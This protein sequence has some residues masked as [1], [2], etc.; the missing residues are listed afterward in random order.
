L[1]SIARRAARTAAVGLT[2][3]SVALFGAVAL[4][5]PASATPE[6]DQ[7][8]ERVEEV[9]E[10]IDELYREAGAANERLLAAQEEYAGAAQELESSKRAVDGQT[11][12]LAEMIG[13]M[14][15]FAAAAYR[16]GVF[17]PTLHLVLSDDVNEAL[18]ES[19]MLDAYA[20]QQASALSTIAAERTA[21][22]AKQADVEEKTALLEDIE[23]T[24]EQEKATLDRKY[25]EAQDLHAS[26]KQDER[27]ELARIEAERERQE[28]LRAEQAAR[29]ARD[30]E[31]E[32]REQ[33][34]AQQ[35]EDQS[36][37]QQGQQTEDAAP[38]AT[39]EPEPEPEPVAPPA[40]GRGGAAVQFALAQVGDAYAYG[41]T[42]PS[43][44]DCSGLTSGAWAA[45][46][47][48]IPRTSQA[49]LYG[50]PQV[51]PSAVQ[52][53]DIIV[54]YGGA[55]HVGIYIGNGQIVHASRPGRPVH[56]APMY[57]MPV[58]GA[59]RPG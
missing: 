36:Q 32:A 15:G 24:I 28:R 41:G 6:L 2:A 10:Q 56:V 21:L 40:S 54:Y 59:V 34:E 49:Q 18:S 7:I 20:D 16:Q 55:S 52:P 42:G 37:A 4:S 57:S 22:S 8:R 44:W 43:A 51:S 53:G 1:T 9:A 3:L 39:P 50:L 14:G 45:A 26:L 48:S 38:A 27:D 5:A 47:V 30:A 58:V 11:Q 46:G 25:Q 23:A 31:R 29:A 33:Q 35:R 13:D 12:Q 17:D 19:V